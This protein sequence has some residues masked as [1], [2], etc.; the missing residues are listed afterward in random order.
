MHNKIIDFNKIV[1]RIN[2]ILFWVLSLFIPVLFLGTL[3]FIWS[4]HS[5]MV[6]L[7]LLTNGIKEKFSNLITF[8]IVAYILAAIANLYHFN[9]SVPK[10]I[11]KDHLSGMNVAKSLLLLSSIILFSLSVIFFK[12]SNLALDDYQLKTTY[13]MLH[14]TLFISSF[15][16]F[17]LFSFF[18]TIS[19]DETVTHAPYYTYKLK[20]RSYNE[21]KNSILRRLNS[22]KLEQ[23]EYYDKD[24][25]ISYYISHEEREYIY[26]FLHLS[27]IEYNF[28][29]I[30]ANE[31]ITPFVEYLYTKILS[32]EKN[33][34]IIYFIAVDT[35]NEDTIYLA[36]TSSYHD[37]HF[38]ILHTIID[39]S[40]KEFLISSVREAKKK[41]DLNYIT[42]KNKVDK[43]IVDIVENVKLTQALLDIKESEDSKDTLPKR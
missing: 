21:I 41:D 14:L 8:N 16:F 25:H 12:L 15:F 18:N 5:Y 31:R 11:R 3:I 13:V 33:V 32:K 37:E 1:K 28:V 19:E 24:L 38:A 17:Y 42:L 40:K 7:N 27:Q 26:A 20:D 2:H 36:E 29:R 30:Y 4:R 10:Q 43:S 9:N 34:S 23:G 22:L 6:E 35:S 39:L